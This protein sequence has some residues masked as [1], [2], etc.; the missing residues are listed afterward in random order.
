[1]KQ[2][3]PTKLKIS[4]R[5]IIYKSLS[6]L[7]GVSRAELARQTG[8]SGATVI[9]IID[10]LLS[11]NIVYYDSVNETSGAVGRKPTPILFNKSFAHV[12]AIH[13]EG[14]Y[15]SAGIV[16]AVGDII[17]VK[18]VKVIDFDDFINKD[19]FELIDKLIISSKIDKSTLVG[20]GLAVPISFDPLSKKMFRAPI[21]K[22]SEQSLSSIS[23]L[24]HHEYNIPVY[25]ENDVNAS[26]YGEYHTYYAG[27]ANDLVYISLGTGLGCGIILDSKIRKG[28]K[29]GSGEIGY[30]VFEPKYES[31]SDVGWLE[32]KINFDAITS[33]FNTDL[34]DYINGFANNEIIDYLSD[35]LSLAVSNIYAVLDVDTIVLGGMLVNYLGGSLIDAVNKKCRLINDL[36]PPV[37]KSQLKHPGFCG[38]GYIIIDRLLENILVEEN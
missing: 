4:N 14:K 31:K 34:K 37:V 23:D 35:Y 22:K 10:Y 18:E 24:L 13:M 38:I 25:V 29:G 3:V 36:I 15:I 19:L 8:I 33:I 1:M 27:V 5:K 7:D 30:M 28:I 20:I 11:K 2:N 16:N 6:A 32:S 21:F 9:K 12:I 17:D 26:A